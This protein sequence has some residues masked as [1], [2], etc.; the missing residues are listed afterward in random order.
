MHSLRQHRAL[1]GLRAL[2]TVER[3][4]SQAEMADAAEAEATAI[5]ERERSGS[6]A[7]VAGRAWDAHLGRDSFDPDIARAL[8]GEWNG[9]VDAASASATIC[10]SKRMA[11]DAARDAWQL[12]E[13]KLRQAEGMVATSRRRIARDREERA[14]ET[15][16][17]RTTYRWNRS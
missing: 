16:A 12:S 5:A 8:A 14:L 11:A 1:R 13:A 4:T 6:A 7:A 2:R 3:G 9:R 15:L 10:E 17:D